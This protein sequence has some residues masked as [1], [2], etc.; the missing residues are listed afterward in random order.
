MPAVCQGVGGLCLVGK[1]V[2]QQDGRGVGR[3]DVGPF[4]LPRITSASCRVLTACP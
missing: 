3:A 1:R 4:P 2:L